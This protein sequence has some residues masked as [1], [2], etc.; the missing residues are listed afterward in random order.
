MKS[1]EC[2]ANCSGYQF[3]LLASKK[4]IKIGIGRAVRFVPVLINKFAKTSDRWQVFTPK[5]KAD[6]SDSFITL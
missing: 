3:Y 4:V 5:T 6:T 2:V 1:N